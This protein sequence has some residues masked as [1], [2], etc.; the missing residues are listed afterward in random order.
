MDH[1]GR[2]SVYKMFSNQSVKCG[3]SRNVEVWKT[4]VKGVTVG[5]RQLASTDW[6]ENAP[7][8]DSSCPVGA[9]FYCF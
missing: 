6:K 8:S 4:A 9:G 1:L 5:Q 3:L 2:N 7:K